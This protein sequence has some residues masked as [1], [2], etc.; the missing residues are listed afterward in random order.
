[1]EAVSHRVHKRGFTLVELLVVI[2]IIVILISLLLPALSRA[3]FQANVVN[4][5]SNLRQ[6]LVATMAYAADNRGYVPPRC[7]AGYSPVDNNG[8]SFIEL[9][10]T[11]PGQSSPTA[12]NLGALMAGG[13]IEREQPDWL[14]AINPATGNPNYYSMGV[15]PVRFDPGAGDIGY[16]VAGMS[17][18]HASGDAAVVWSSSYEFNPHWGF[19]SLGG[20]WANGNTI[21]TC[22]ATN[23]G[24]DEVSWYTK[25]SSFNPNKALVTDLNSCGAEA[26][27]N[28]VGFVPHMG[29]SAWVYNLG[30]IDGHVATVQ[31]KAMMHCTAGTYS[32]Y[33]IRIPTDT[34]GY[35]SMLD[36]LEAEADGRDPVT[37]G[38]DPTMPPLTRLLG[39]G[40]SGSPFEYR[41]EGPSGANVPGEQTNSSKPGYM[42]Y[43]PSVPWL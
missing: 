16:E 26:N 23:S 31:D 27:T 19:T 39:T 13:Y 3:R 20:K 30:F 21:N 34:E 5:S 7:W 17:G 4:C 25:I 33:P 28:F 42:Q 38:G 11:M 29:R 15:A 6:I 8:F 35:D 37:S 22:S 14:M 41:L 24:G 43:H 32:G 2:G 10:Y 9:A 1:M 40:N 18:S 36:T 12:S